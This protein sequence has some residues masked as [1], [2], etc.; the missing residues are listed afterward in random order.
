MRRKREDRQIH[1]R[2]IRVEEAEK[3]PKYENGIPSLLTG[4]RATLRLFGE[5][6]T[7]DTVITFT[8]QERAYGGECQMPATEPFRV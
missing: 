5:G 6:F 7:E 2:G 8:H 4:T 3:E 1:I